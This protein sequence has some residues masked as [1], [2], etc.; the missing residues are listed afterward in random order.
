VI[1]PLLTL[2]CGAPIE[3]E[4]RAP[5][6]L[7]RVVERE[8]RIARP[9]ARAFTDVARAGVEERTKP[10]VLIGGRF[11]LDAKLGS[12]GHATVWR[13][14]DTRGGGLVA[15]KL[16]H[17]SFREHPE[18]LERF[19]RELAVL[20]SLDHPNIARAIDG[21]LDTSIPWLAMRR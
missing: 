15:V 17:R 20:T 11:L 7:R 10:G 1:I 8:R 19:H 13:A 9:P 2:A 12:G 4:Q 21:A 18:A 16:I 6:A 3:G 14:R 5:E